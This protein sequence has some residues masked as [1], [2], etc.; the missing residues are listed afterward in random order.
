MAITKTVKFTFAKETKGA[1]Q[2]KEVAEAGDEIIGSL[3]LRKS[4]IKGIP[5][6]LTVT[7]EYKVKAESVEVKETKKADAPKK[8]RK[9]RQDEE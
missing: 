5:K 7:V 2:Y 8:K 9:M 3:Y 4:A 6:R 1:V